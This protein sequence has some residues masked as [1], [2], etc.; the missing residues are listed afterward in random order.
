MRE[1]IAARLGEIVFRVSKR[2]NI[3]FKVA[4]KLTRYLKAFLYENIRFIKP[5]I[6]REDLVNDPKDVAF[7][8][9]AVNLKEKYQKVYIIT[10]NKK[11]YRMDLLG[12]E[13]VKVLSPRQ[14][15]ELLGIDKIRLD[16]VLSVDPVMG[17][18]LFGVTLR[19][20]IGSGK[21]P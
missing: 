19:K 15:E 17:M 8:S 1:E 14:L 16:L 21:N 4:L 20:E 5:S 12:K 7:A 6:K 9:L 2:K 3:T 10:F 13:G 18:V 11:D